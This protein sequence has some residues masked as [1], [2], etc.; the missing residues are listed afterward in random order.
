MVPIMVIEM[1]MRHAFAWLYSKS[2]NGDSSIGK[3]PAQAHTFL[4][5]GSGEGGEPSA[6]TTLAMKE[7]IGC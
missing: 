3:K 4:L 6:G 7:T 5:D 2:G 1:S